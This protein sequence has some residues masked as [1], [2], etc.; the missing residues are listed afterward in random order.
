MVLDIL[1]IIVCYAFCSFSLATINSR[2]HFLCMSVNVHVALDDNLEC[3]E[4]DA[5][6]NNYPD[7]TNLVKQETMMMVN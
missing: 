1:E 4:L 3:I 5:G 7:G 6:G 2:D